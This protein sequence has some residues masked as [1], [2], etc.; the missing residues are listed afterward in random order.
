MTSRHNERFQQRR[1]AL[2]E[3]HKREL[4]EAKRRQAAQLTSITAYDQRMAKLE[5]ARR[6][7]ATAVAEAV[8]AFGGRRDAAAAL[9]LTA[10][11]MREY[12]ATHEEHA[13]PSRADERAAEERESGER[14]ADGRM[15][16]GRA[17]TAEEP[18]VAEQPAVERWSSAEQS[19]DQHAPRAPE[20]PGRPAGPAAPGVPAPD[21][22]DVPTANPV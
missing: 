2:R 5:E 8:T 21:V 3:Q 16:D 15:A 18:A 4:E 20:E 17:A 13:A 14:M 9:G 6:D 22:P 10:A 1:Q 7:V 11:E 12:L 19:A